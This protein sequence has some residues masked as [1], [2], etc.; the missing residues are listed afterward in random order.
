MVMLFGTGGAGVSDEMDLGALLQE[1]NR[2]LMYRQDDEAR[3]TYLEVWR[4]ASEMGDEYYACAAAHMLGV[5]ESMPLEEK[6]H[7][8]LVSLERANR[9]EDGRV[10]S[11]YA[12]I[13]VNLGH[14]HRL[15]NQP[16]DALA[17]YEQ[18]LLHS[19]SMDD[20]SYAG[21]IRE[22]IEKALAEL[23]DSVQPE[24]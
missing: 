22:P 14:V 18:A 2:L 8:H 12:S 6:L 21:S 20:P 3:A 1:G 19:H 24:L 17:C 13:Y 5:M 15:L 10:D 23:R 9:V 11:W 16:A 7:W 4:R